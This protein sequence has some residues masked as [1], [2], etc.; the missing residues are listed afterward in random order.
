VTWKSPRMKTSTISSS[1]RAHCFRG[2]MKC[3]MGDLFW[4]RSLF[5]ISRLKPHAQSEIAD[6]GRPKDG[7]LRYSVFG[8]MI[9]IVSLVFRYDKRILLKV[10]DCVSDARIGLSWPLERGWYLEMKVDEYVARSW[11]WILL[12]SEW[13][14]KEDKR[15]KERNKRETWW[16]R[17][18]WPCR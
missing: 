18:P 14:F 13:I 15:V 17:E 7:T 6:C 2:E 10:N 12:G 8:I 3:D 4:S 5:R 1:L 11:I 16:F 9:W